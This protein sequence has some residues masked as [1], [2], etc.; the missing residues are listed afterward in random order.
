MEYFLLNRREVVS[1][2]ECWNEF[3]IIFINSLG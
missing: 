2:S 3:C 1:V